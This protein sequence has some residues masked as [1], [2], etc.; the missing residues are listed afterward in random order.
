MNKLPVVVPDFISQEDI[1]K[2]IHL[3]NTSKTYVFKNNSTVK[4]IPLRESE[5][6]SVALLKKYSDKVLIEHGVENLSTVEGF[7]SFWRYGASAA[8]HKDNHEDF[9]YLTNS[10]IIYLNDDYEGGEIYFPN[11]NFTYKPKKGDA[12][13][14][15]CNTENYDHGVKE[16]T[17]GNR[18]TI[19]M[20]HSPITEKA[21]PLLN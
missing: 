10:T 21:H 5:A 19:A 15:P 8:V 17:S 14:F 3:L 2:A 18:Y 7:L 9:E 16:V 20:W 6:E 13:I 11:L 4:I 12:I 1:D